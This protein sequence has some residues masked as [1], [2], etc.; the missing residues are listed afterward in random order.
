MASTGASSSSAGDGISPSASSGSLDAAARE[1][2]LADALAPE[3]MR[4]QLADA[5][6]AADAGGAEAREEE[7]AA[8]A[9]FRAVVDGD[10]LAKLTSAERK[11]T[12]GAVA[13]VC[14]GLDGDVDAAHAFLRVVVVDLLSLDPSH[15]D[16]VLPLSEPAPTTVEEQDAR[17][18]LAAETFVDTLDV[19]SARA[20]PSSPEDAPPT[21]E[22]RR[23]TEIVGALM[24]ASTASRRYTAHAGAALQRLA[25]AA[26]V[27]WS[28]ISALE[29][30]L[31]AHLR[32][33]LA[34]GD[35]PSSSSSTQ[36]S[37]QSS[38]S[39][40]SSWLTRALTRDAD[41]NASGGGLL[42]SF[43]FKSFGRAATI[44]A[45]AALGGGLLF[46]TGGLAAPAMV[47]SLSTLGA[48]GGVVGAVA[49][50]AGTLIAAFGGTAGISVV[51]GGVGAGLVGW[52]VSRR[53]EGLS[54]F[55]FL[56]VRGSGAGLSVFLFVPGFLRDPAD[57][58]RTWGASDGVYAV[59]IHLP[60]HR[61]DDEGNE[62][63]DEDAEDAVWGAAVRGMGMWLRRD[64]RT[65]EVV[66]SW[67]DEGGAAERAGV[68]VGSVLTAVAVGGGPPRRV[69]RG[70][71][72][73]P[74]DGS[75]LRLSR[76]RAILAGRERRRGDGSGGAGGG[77]ARA[78]TAEL[79]LRRNLGAGADLDTLAR[80][81]RPLGKL[82][83]RR[84]RERR[85]LAKEAARMR[86]AG[87]DGFERAVDLAEARSRDEGPRA[88]TATTPATAT[89]DT[90]TN[91]RVAAEDE[92]SNPPDSESNAD[93]DSGSDS[94]ADG[95]GDGDDS[96]EASTRGAPE[97]TAEGDGLIRAV[98]QLSANTM[99]SLTFATT[100][101][102]DGVSDA[103]ISA[104]SGVASAA[105]FA[106]SAT[107]RVAG[108]EAAEAEA[109]EAEAVKLADAWPLP[110]G[111]QLVVGWEH[112][113]LMDLGG[114]MSS[115]GREA[116]TAYVGAKA[117]SYT[118]LASL[119]AAVAWPV[120]L[121]NSAS[122]IDSPWALA[123]SRAV[124]A[125]EELAAALA[126][127]RHGVR[128]VTLVGY[129]LGAKVILA[130]ARALA[131]RED[132]AG[133]GLVQDVVLVGAPVDTSE[134]TWAPLR[135]VAAG[136]VVN[137]YAGSGSSNGDWMLQF[138]FRKNA[139]L[140]RRG[141]SAWSPAS[142][143]GVENVDV[144]DAGGA[145]MDI[146]DNMPKIL[147]RVGLE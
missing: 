86:C 62:R 74:A 124:D 60:T 138:L 101:A 147:E 65:R 108:L 52:R 116:I 29:D 45:A 13:C 132:G 94:D 33:I 56:P 40:S 122:F 11:A 96:D 16:A 90:D 53:T 38:S 54:Q 123:E 80:R 12:A 66:V 88:T 20:D 113:L 85:R 59:V 126:E 57:L 73:C 103:A 136:R 15:V 133:L 144:G 68:A 145:H 117:V 51:F 71:E 24:V 127:K 39:S 112:A 19:S 110:R 72:D 146:P 139:M 70:D 119:A 55:A 128:P 102:V 131:A 82:A 79:W 99:R 17:V 81:R 50:S 26:R 28:S 106:A 18:R 43:G 111:E 36:S 140:V 107:A 75:V 76:V 30:V 64:A 143:P 48:A 4:V 21:T 83:W 87:G 44:G 77:D 104:V 114:A 49:L 61:E 95:E 35:A 118:A 46:V 1:A 6:H 31:A 120:T 3:I 27:P 47:A 137:A 130:A 142:H 98:S 14:V 93:S 115:F 69:R 78:A 105:T 7:T 92:P 9:L 109:V 22:L 89:P 129:S 5:R 42:P 125:G 63:A 41:A 67:L 84:K 23:W 10:A 37:T 32:S 91:R 97:T 100:R 135:R 25:R 121:L 134:E 141:L 34:R 2:A 8:A 58:F